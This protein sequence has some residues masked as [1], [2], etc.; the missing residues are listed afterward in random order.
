MT[1]KRCS[2]STAGSRRD[3]IVARL[4]ATGPLLSCEVVLERWIHPHFAVKCCFCLMRMSGLLVGFLQWTKA[5]LPCLSKSCGSEECFRALRG[6][7][8]GRDVFFC[9]LG[10]FVAGG[11]VFFG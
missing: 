4:L 7:I 8:A 11:G 5:G 10:G 9:C 3:F 6:A 1:C 2:G